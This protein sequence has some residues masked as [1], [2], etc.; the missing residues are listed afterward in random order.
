[1]SSDDD[2]SE[3]IVEE[4]CN[5]SD[6]DGNVSNSER[7]SSL[8]PY[9]ALQ[10]GE[11]S[12]SNLLELGESIR[13]EY[14]R[15]VDPRSFSP[16][17]KDFS[18]KPSQFEGHSIISESILCN[19][20]TKQN[21]TEEEKALEDEEVA[22]K[23]S[24]KSSFQN[25]NH[26]QKSKIL[27]CC[28]GNEL[29]G[30]SDLSP[31]SS[32]WSAESFKTQ[33]SG[34][35]SVYIKDRS[36]SEISVSVP[37]LSVFSLDSAQKVKSLVK[38]FSS[39]DEETD[40]PSI[41]AIK[42]VP[43]QLSLPVELFRS[44]SAM[45]SLVS[46]Q[47]EEK[48]SSVVEGCF[49]THSHRDCVSC[50]VCY[51]QSQEKET[52]SFDKRC[53]ELPRKFNQLSPRVKASLEK[54][55][56]CL[57]KGSSLDSQT[58]VD[59]RK[60]LK[61]K[62]N[63]KSQQK[64][65]KVIK[66]LHVS[67][68][69]NSP[70]HKAKLKESLERIYE[71]KDHS[72]EQAKDSPDTGIL[73][74]WSSSCQ[75]SPTKARRAVSPTRNLHDEKGES[76]CEN[77]KNL[78]NS[79]ATHE[80]ICDTEEE[81][82]DMPEE[83]ETKIVSGYVDKENDNVCSR[84]EGLPVATSHHLDR[85]NSSLE[86]SNLR[87]SCDS[88]GK[89]D[90]C[91]LIYSH[92]GFQEE[93]LSSNHN[94]RSQKNKDVSLGINRIVKTPLNHFK[95]DYKENANICDTEEDMLEE[96]DGK[97]M[98]DYVDEENDSLC[99]SKE[100]T[101]LG[102]SPHMDSANSSL[103][104]AE[105]QIICG[106][107]GEA[108]NGDV[109]CSHSGS[110]EENFFGSH[111]T[112][113]QIGEEDA[114][115]T[116]NK[117][118]ETPLNHSNLEYKDS[119]HFCAAESLNQS[120]ESKVQ[121]AAMSHSNT[122]DVTTSN[123]GMGLVNASKDN[124]LLQSEKRKKNDLQLLESQSEF[125]LSLENESC[126]ELLHID[127]DHS[128]DDLFASDFSDT[129]EIVMGL[130]SKS[131]ISAITERT[132]ESGQE[133]ENLNHRLE[134]ESD[135]SSNSNKD[136][137]N[138]LVAHTDSGNECQNIE[139]R[140]INAGA[141]EGPTG[142]KHYPSLPFTIVNDES[143]QFTGISSAQ[144]GSLVQ[145]HVSLQVR[146]EPVHTHSSH[147]SASAVG[148]SS[149]K[150]GTKAKLPVFAGHVKTSKRFE[151]NATP[152]LSPTIKSPSGPVRATLH[153]NASKSM[154][155]LASNHGSKSKTQGL[156]NRS[157]SVSTDSL[158]RN[159]LRA[160]SLS[161]GP[162]SRQ[163]VKCG[164]E[165]G[166]GNLNRRC[167]S[168]IALNEGEGQINLKRNKSFSLSK[169]NRSR[170][171]SLTSIASSRKIDYSQIPSKVRQY[172][173]DMKEKDLRNSTRSLPSTPARRSMQQMA[174]QNIILD[175]KFLRELSQLDESDI[176]NDMR[177]IRKQILGE[178]CDRKRHEEIL[179]LLINERKL[180]HASDTTLATL[181]LRYDNLNARFAEK[182]NEIDRLRFY[183]DI[184]ISK[185]YNISI[186][187]QEEG[188]C[189]KSHN[190]TQPNTP[191]R[192]ADRYEPTPSLSERR[193]S[194]HVTP[195]NSPNIR[196]LSPTINSSNLIKTTHTPIIDPKLS[197]I[198][199]PSI[200]HAFED[201]IQGDKT[202][203]QLILNDPQKT[204]D[205]EITSSSQ[206]EVCLQSWMKDASN[207]LKKLKEFALLE[208]SA[209]LQQSERS[210][211]WHSILHQYWCLSSQF[212]VL[213]LL[214]S[215]HEPGHMLQ[216]LGQSLQAT[217]SRFE[218]DLAARKYQEGEL[219]LSDIDTVRSPGGDTGVI[220]G[221]S[222]NIHAA[223]SRK[224]VEV[225][226]CEDG[227][228][229]LISTANEQR[230]YDIDTTVHNCGNSRK[231]DVLGCKKDVTGQDN[232]S[233]LHFS[234]AKRSREHPGFHGN[235]FMK[236]I[237]GVNENLTQLT[238]KS[239]GTLHR[240]DNTGDPVL[241]P[242]A[243]SLICEND[244]KKSLINQKTMPTEDLYPM[245]E[246]P[247]GHRFV[248][249]KIDTSAAAVCSP[250]HSRE[251]MKTVGPLEKVKL[252]QAS[253]IDPE[254]PHT[255]YQSSSDNSPV[256]SILS[257][258]SSHPFDPREDINNSFTSLQH[259]PDQ[260]PLNTG[261]T[262]STD[263]IGILKNVKNKEA[264]NLQGHSVE[265]SP[266]HSPER[267]DCDLP[268]CSWRSNSMT[269]RLSWGRMVKA[270]DLDS[271]CP[272]S[273]Q[274]T[275][276][277]HNA[278][279]DQPEQ[280]DMPN[281]QSSLDLATNDNDEIPTTLIQPL[282]TSRCENEEQADD[283]VSNKHI[284]KSGSRCST[285][286]CYE[287]KELEHE[288]D[289]SPSI[290]LVTVAF[291]RLGACQVMMD[292]KKS[293]TLSG[294]RSSKN[295]TKN[296][297][298]HCCRHDKQQG[299]KDITRNERPLS[300]DYS[301]MDESRRGTNSRNSKVSKDSVVNGRNSHN[302]DTEFNSGILQT[303]QRTKLKKMPDM[304]ALESNEKSRGRHSDKT[305]ES[306]RKEQN[307]KR[308]ITSPLAEED[309]LSQTKSRKYSAKYVNRNSS[310]TSDMSISSHSIH[311][312][313]SKLKRDLNIIKSQMMNLTSEVFHENKRK[314]KGGCKGSSNNQTS[315]LEG[316]QKPI[317]ALEVSIYSD[318]CEHDSDITVQ[319][320]QA[321]NN[322]K[323]SCSKY[324][325]S[326][327]IKTGKHHRSFLSDGNSQDF[328]GDTSVQFSNSSM[329]MLSESFL[330][331]KMERLPK[332]TPNSKESQFK[333][334]K[335]KSLPN[336]VNNK[337][338]KTVK[339]MT[340][341]YETKRKLCF[342]NEVETS[343][344]RDH[345]TN[346][347]RSFGTL[348]F[349][350]LDTKHVSVQTE[351]KVEGSHIC[352]SIQTASANET[353]NEEVKNESSQTKHQGSQ[354]I[355]VPD[356]QLI[357]AAA[358]V[359]YI[360]NYNCGSKPMEVNP[361]CDNEHKTSPHKGHSK[362]RRAGSAHELMVSL[363]EATTLAERLRLRSENMLSYLNL[364]FTV[365][366]NLNSS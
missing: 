310:D 76:G 126:D 311:N 30:A 162:L 336:S 113:S 299:V 340:Q 355:L 96:K 110:Q 259:D 149:F 144:E 63:I 250:A 246:G 300:S 81:V 151:K 298:D 61:S 232:Q 343:E 116:V 347:K 293:S 79:K 82:E 124:C 265:N 25:R 38:Q 364:H 266:L 74:S 130:I 241:L 146:S 220:K 319:S 37:K 279:L 202:S 350:H 109:M 272:G 90:H 141:M 256:P 325:T 177:E 31:V 33:S 213:T 36:V 294:S 207:L 255:A 87:V 236:K 333:E 129:S 182:Q 68:K 23:R 57:S 275:R 179:N 94:I 175:E 14:K 361:L 132:E 157:M 227:S 282:Q 60:I 262:L 204:G 107:N 35:N 195:P 208:G 83:K 305:Y 142:E 188:R 278:S 133:I 285:H 201:S 156:Q 18:D 168:A 136:F 125:S 228:K 264:N 288:A 215:S 12:G 354:S 115:L 154:H 211:I 245:L 84:E 39:Q 7:D 17:A 206:G 258:D 203:N 341:G 140:V 52:H 77:S 194:Y 243:T 226:S 163:T 15:N 312:N 104:P 121:T 247:L 261:K 328:Q 348:P 41:G 114:S 225:D 11:K 40:V 165:S 365:H 50:M 308:S 331:S 200:S 85:A 3:E 214:P 88:G 46:M 54:I 53:R 111:I 93:K 296:R 9:V 99:L 72:Q 321:F 78:I 334:Q 304:K 8:F 10:T 103:G 352:K 233:A 172:I 26:K 221:K 185:E 316:R 268:K 314:R 161:P 105:L 137:M 16:N 287:D 357:S 66:P 171:S 292:N 32:D 100:K 324:R 170:S 135:L 253:L 339:D 6:S 283:C 345:H 263:C 318:D 235:T 329:D 307:T 64:T 290:D 97:L 160:K 191:G 89:V 21:E 222:L 217:A 219:I 270:R 337:V 349:S 45:N 291:P 210:I 120:S 19:S 123:S 34:S 301:I 242:D 158:E 362:H 358:P 267:L 44:T 118:V 244:S 276:V 148:Q 218:L 280:L 332:S 153:R 273:E 309:H 360:Q 95:I 251:S 196:S 197:I 169:L 67:E 101:S 363:D 80:D 187:S 353:N 47:H 317:K 338:A 320:F 335:T 212:P 147:P 145:T 303:H 139:Q 181:Q 295:S 216:E 248:S 231:T 269:P 223:G 297:R 86:P 356:A 260:M 330:E 271:G 284:I 189:N 155:N 152:P 56:T 2:T 122:F 174:S 24:H 108:A 4:I 27:K 28:S 55:G 229:K 13:D 209:V 323:S 257:L 224:S 106:S 5:H 128:G 65:N 98:S 346:C 178:K 286:S 119:V 143:S 102:R 51:F 29:T 134:K 252:W 176:P 42:S 281:L 315:Y 22:S 186:K 112:A 359:I 237:E 69:E 277:S 289:L 230:C 48:C 351:S 138:D 190:T 302:Q 192:Y 20:L 322:P 198:Y 70:C 131:P 240:V 327:L 164:S 59:E 91:V 73:H 239:Y 166:Q 342:E 193:S 150:L 238:Q 180:R 75:S 173:K 205:L 58:N 326:M 249:G 117:M 306:A 62:E 92:A 184:H 183:K 254:V 199:D 43:R 1:M 274:S 71:K 167:I 127:I 49:D 159:S 366:S 234:P 344:I 313:I